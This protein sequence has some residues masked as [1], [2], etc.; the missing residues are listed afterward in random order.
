MDAYEHGIAATST[1]WAHWHVIPADHKWDCRTLVAEIICR[2][3]DKLKLAFPEPG[4][5]DQAKLA[6][7]RSRLEQE[8]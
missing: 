3:L 6:E 4:L 5:D 1:D 2:K 8:N 7:A